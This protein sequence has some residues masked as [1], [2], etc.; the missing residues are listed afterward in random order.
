MKDNFIRYKDALK[1]RYQEVKSGPDAAYLDYPTWAGLRD[2]CEEKY[3]AEVSSIDEEIFKTFFGKT[4]VRGKKDQIEK[5]TNPFRPL[6]KFLRNESD[7]ADKTSAD[8]LAVLLDFGDRPYNKFIQKT[9]T[10]LEASG[11]LRSGT[12]TKNGKGKEGMGIEAPG[13]PNSR[14]ILIITIMKWLIALVLLTVV[15]LG[16][17]YRTGFFSN[18]RCLQWN[19]DQYI[20]VAC[21][22]EIKTGD[23]GLVEYNNDLSDFRK[24]IP[25]ATTVPYG[26]GKPKL[27]KGRNEDGVLEYYNKPGKHPETGN[28]LDAISKSEARKM[29]EKF[30][31]GEQQ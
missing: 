22:E 11:R 16:V 19:G 20:P 9:N 25:N 1:V 13:L 2:F 15:V 12:L 24:V 5:D 18:K 4:F 29:W 31:P 17:L 26:N 6:V 30:H 7:L 23:F 21:S 8:L 14:R 10:E 28:I 27:W 3:A